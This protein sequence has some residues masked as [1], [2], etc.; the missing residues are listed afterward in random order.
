M[1]RQEKE[2]KSGFRD[3]FKTYLKKSELKNIRFHNLRHTHATLL[4]KQG[5]HP[6]IVSERLDHKDVFITLNRY[7][8]FSPSLQKDAVKT[9]NDR[10]F[11][12]QCLQI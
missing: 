10:L 2:D 12:W 9:F 4:L 7:S 11:G 1:Q 6:K 8:H 5:V 3:T